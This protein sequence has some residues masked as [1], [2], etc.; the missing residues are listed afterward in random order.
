MSVHR[1][2]RNALIG[3]GARSLAGLAATVGPLALVET[4]TPVALLLGALALVFLAYGVRT[5]ARVPHRIKVDEAEIAAT[6][7]RPVLLRWVD[8]SSMKLN[9]YSTK[10]DGRGGWMQLKLNAGGRTLRIESTLEGFSEVVAR[11][12]RAADR[13]GIEL[14]PATTANLSLLGIRGGRGRPA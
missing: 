14:P 10:R 13:R 9:Y 3:D 4:S 5:V 8:L 7:L 12:A 6:G 2:R 11:A 1:Y